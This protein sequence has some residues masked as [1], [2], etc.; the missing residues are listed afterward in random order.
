MQHTNNQRNRIA[1]NAKPG[2]VKTS[3]VFHA[4]S[5]LS[6]VKIARQ[7]HKGNSEYLPQRRQGRKERR[8]IINNFF[9]IIHLFPPN[10]ACFAPWRESSPL[11]ESFIPCYVER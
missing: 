3:V 5:T 7:S 1:Q 2:R 10:L 8:M 9:K 6:G 11:I 4:V